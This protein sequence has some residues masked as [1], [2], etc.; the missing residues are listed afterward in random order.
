MTT[1]PLTV[2]LAQAALHNDPSPSRRA[3][4]P[5]SRPVRIVPRT[6]LDPDRQLVDKPE[7]SKVAAKKKRAKLTD[8][9]R[10]VAVARVEKLIE[11]GNPS[12]QAIA[13]V[14]KELGVSDSAIH[15]WR[16]AANN[17]NKNNGALELGPVKLDGLD[18]ILDII[19]L[20]DR[21]KKG[22]SRNQ[23]AKLKAMIVERLS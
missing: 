14:S 12:G 21:A 13:T 15:N 4:P 6:A 7:A 16:A 22:L 3:A 20:C 17:K 8:E 9:T 2:P 10:S 23:R 11:A 18:L 19:E 5:S 1:T